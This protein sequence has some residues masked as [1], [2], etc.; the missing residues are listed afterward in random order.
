M[1]KE[2]FDDLLQSLKEAKAISRENNPRNP[3]TGIYSSTSM[4]DGVKLK[5]SKSVKATA[6]HPEADVKHIVKDTVRWG[7]APVPAKSSVSL[8]LDND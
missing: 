5:S 4:T 8:R 2:L 7:L 6:E 3:H 1:D